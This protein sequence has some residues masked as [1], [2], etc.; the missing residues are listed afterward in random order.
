[1]AALPSSEKPPRKGGRKPGPPEAKQRHVVSVRLTDA[2]H[3]RLTAAVAT[4]KI[5]HGEVLRAAWCNPNA[6]LAR[7][8]PP[9]PE[10]ARDIARLAG[11][12][13]ELTAFRQQPLTTP[14]LE[15]GLLVVLRQMHAL[16]K[17]LSGGGE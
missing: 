1:M 7:P 16:L 15:Q 17:Q 3:V 10:R 14:T 6:S 2:E 12:A 4:Y 13:D 8:V 9:S 11:M 5:S